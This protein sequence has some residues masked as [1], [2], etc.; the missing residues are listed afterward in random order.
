MAFS[1]SRVAVL[2]ILAVALLV[3]ITCRIMLMTTGA[4]IYFH[5]ALQFGVCITK[6]TSAS[7]YGT[8]LSDLPA[9]L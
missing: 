1:K 4:V 5:M 3:E 7:F 9:L 8:T 6:I 2:Y